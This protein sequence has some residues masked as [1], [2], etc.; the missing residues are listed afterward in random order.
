ME[1]PNKGNIVG[2]KKAFEEE[3]R[4]SLCNVPCDPGQPAECSKTI[5]LTLN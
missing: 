4:N 3:S 2:K 5:S 1:V